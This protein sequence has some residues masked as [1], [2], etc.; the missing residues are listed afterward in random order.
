MI[1][2]WCMRRCDG[3]EKTK[4]LGTAWHIGH[5]IIT[6]WCNVSTMRCL[7]DETSWWFNLTWQWVD[8]MVARE[9]LDDG[10]EKTKRLGTAWHIGHLIITW[11]GDV[12]T[13]RRL[14]NET[15]WRYNLTWWQE[16][17][18]I[19]WLDGKVMTQL[20]SVMKWVND[21]VRRHL[22][23]TWQQGGKRTF[24]LCELMAKWWHNSTRRWD[25]W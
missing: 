5:P 8:N 1:R 17:F 11:L 2:R 12:S 22:A 18:L 16:N 4:R 3:N 24:G 9:H 25:T 14:N 7:D 23:M 21:K 10:D 15:S 13:M 19:L 20:K 6:R